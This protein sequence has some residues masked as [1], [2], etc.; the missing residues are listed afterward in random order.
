MLPSVRSYG[1]Y[2][3]CPNTKHFY[4]LHAML[5]DKQKTNFLHQILLLRTKHVAD[6]QDDNPFEGAQIS[7]NCDIAV[8]LCSNSPSRHECRCYKFCTICLMLHSIFPICASFK[9]ATLVSTSTSA[10]SKSTTSR[11]LT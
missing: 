7:C 4:L 6:L 1:C 11:R 3:R 9:S 8:F 10:S 2:S 5:F